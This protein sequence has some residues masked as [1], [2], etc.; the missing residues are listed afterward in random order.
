MKY[1]NGLFVFLFCIQSFAQGIQLGGW[2]GGNFPS[3]S[4]GLGGVPR[5]DN[6]NPDAWNDGGMPNFS[7][8]GVIVPNSTDW[9]LPKDIESEAPAVPTPG[10]GVVESDPQGLTLPEPV[11][12][13]DNVPFTP[14][15]FA[16]DVMEQ[17]QES[18]LI[19]L[20]DVEPFILPD[21]FTVEEI[22]TCD[23]LP[24]MTALDYVSGLNGDT[25][26]GDRARQYHWL[27]AAKR[28]CAKS[29]NPSADIAL[30][31][32]DIRILN[33]EDPKCV[34]MDADAYMEDLQMAETEVDAIAIDALYG[35]LF[36]CN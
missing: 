26:G 30:S 36:L 11:V 8:D 2:S 23:S 21:D 32:D 35:Y 14:P 5:M 7:G 34:F 12:G 13:D 10:N 6:V 1:L 16:F 17:L 31:L 9:I 19:D 4:G 24:K 22:K 33:P 27:W 25:L 29:T 20:G 28:K 3:A 18:G 15:A